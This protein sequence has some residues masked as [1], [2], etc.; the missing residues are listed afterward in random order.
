[1]KHNVL[2]ICLCVFF[3]ILLSCQANQTTPASSCQKARK[4]TIQKEENPVPNEK[5][6]V[7]IMADKHIIASRVDKDSLYYTCLDAINDSFITVIFKEQGKEYRID[8][9]YKDIFDM[10][11]SGELIF[12]IDLPPFDVKK[13]GYSEEILSKNPHE[14]FSLVVNPYEYGIGRRFIGIH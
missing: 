5:F 9:I 6:S 10:S 1:M 3:V 12:R 8:S 14:I 13:Y 7:I 2:V 4:L 11:Q